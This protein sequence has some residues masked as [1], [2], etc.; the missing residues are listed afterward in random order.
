MKK[1]VQN[2][3]KGTAKLAYDRLLPAVLLIIFGV[4]AYFI[5]NYAVVGKRHIDGTSIN[6]Y[7]PYMVAIG[8]GI[9][10]YCVGKLI[11]YWFINSDGNNDGIDNMDGFPFGAF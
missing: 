4:A 3:Q 8:I 2:Y 6:W 11:C 5:F 7:E 1:Q 9:I 10:G